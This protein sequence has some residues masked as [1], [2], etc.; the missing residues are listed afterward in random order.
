MAPHFKESPGGNVLTGREGTLLGISEGRCQR[1]V[2][3]DRSGL[4]DSTLNLGVM[5]LGDSIKEESTNVLLSFDFDELSGQG[6]ALLIQARDQILRDAIRYEGGRYL[7]GEEEKAVIGDV[8]AEVLAGTLDKQLAGQGV[9]LDLVFPIKVIHQPLNNKNGKRNEQKGEQLSVALEIKGHYTPP[10]ELDFDRIVQDSINRE[11][12]TL[13]RELTY[14]N[15]NCRDQTTKVL[16]LGYSQSDFSEVH[17]MKGVRPNRGRGEEMVLSNIFRT[18]CSEA[19]VLPEYFE[20]SLNHIDAKQI[21]S[22][23]QLSTKEVSILDSDM[24]PPWKIVSLILLAGFLCLFMAFTYFRQAR[25]KKKA[26]NGETILKSSVSYS[27]SNLGVVEEENQRNA[28]EENEDGSEKNSESFKV[29]ASPGD[30]NTFCHRLSPMI[31][32]GLERIR[33]EMGNMAAAIE[34]EHKAVQS[35]LKIFN[36]RKGGSTAEP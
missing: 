5:R 31:H 32:S 6:R 33:Q 12:P 1:C 18:V 9:E 35:R 10:P 30:Q 3:V 4:P 21:S 14:Y 15:E 16:D 2:S 34:S 19:K 13:R 28:T 27:N 36:E 11:T 24:K 25:K 20:T 7:L 29:V 23:Q 17:S 26:Q 22:S 8:A